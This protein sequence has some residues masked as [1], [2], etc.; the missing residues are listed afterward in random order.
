VSALAAQVGGLLFAV[1]RGYGLD[2]QDIGGGQQLI[3]PVTEER[4]AV[5]VQASFGAFLRSPG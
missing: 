4:I 1:S 2:L 3:D 5:S